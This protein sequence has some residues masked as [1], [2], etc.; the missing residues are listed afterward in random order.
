MK[1]AYILIK[2]G[3][4][5]TIIRDVENQRAIIRGENENER[6]RIAVEIRKRLSALEESRDNASRRADAI[7]RVDGQEGVSAFWTAV[8]ETQATRIDVWR[9][10]LQ[11]VTGTR[12]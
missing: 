1:R 9:E 8:A 3:R 7:G 10:C 2:D 11:I 4:R 12:S 5:E 6:T